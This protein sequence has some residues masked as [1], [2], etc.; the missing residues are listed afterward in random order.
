MCV[1]RDENKWKRGRGCPFLKI[2]YIL[3]QGWRGHDWADVDLHSFHFRLWKFHRQ[4][5]ENL[6]PESRDHRRQEV[7]LGQD[8]RK[9]EGI[10]TRYQLPWLSWQGLSPIKGWCAWFLLD[11]HCDTWITAMICC[12]QV[13]GNCGSHLEG[14]SFCYFFKDG[15]FPTSFSLFSSFLFKCTIGR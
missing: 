6:A 10:R 9:D 2:K 5:L 12:C 11:C 1:W 4:E 3:F 7:H 14:L 8:V 15:P 13:D